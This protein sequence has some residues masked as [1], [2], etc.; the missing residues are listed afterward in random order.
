MYV[1]LCNVA[2]SLNAKCARHADRFR[3]F[4]ASLRDDGPFTSH[5]K[6]VS[7]DMLI[8]VG[9]DSAHLFRSRQ[10]ARCMSVFLRLLGSVCLSVSD[11]PLC[12]SH[13][14]LSRMFVH[15]CM[16]GPPTTCN[17]PPSFSDTG[18]GLCE[19]H[20]PLSHEWFYLFGQKHLLDVRKSTLYKSVF[21]FIDE[22]EQH[23]S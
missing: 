6:L 7:K 18:R 16:R 2:A 14:L 3:I 21:L 23:W 17:H 1:W 20:L 15:T 12:A 22:Y 9:Q 4:W 5:L 13:V 10:E 8:F 11:T 19:H